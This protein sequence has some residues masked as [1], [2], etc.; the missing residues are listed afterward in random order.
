[1]N[2]RQPQIL[3]CTSDIGVHLIF[4]HEPETALDISMYLRHG[5]VP[6]DAH[7]G[8]AHLGDA[9]LGDAHLGDA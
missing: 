7:L 6:Q 4:R 9:H 8:D 1:M 3:A 5:R 2:L